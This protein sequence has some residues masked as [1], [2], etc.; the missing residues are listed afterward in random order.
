MK[1]IS[2][3]ILSLLSIILSAQDTNYVCHFENVSLARLEKL[4]TK[5]IEFSPIYYQSGLVFVEARERNSILDPKTGQA[6][7]DLMYADL[8][9]D[10]MPDKSIFFSPNIQT[11]YHEGPCTFSQ[12]GNEIF[13]TRS[14]M[15]GGQVVNDEKK[16]VQLKIYHGVKGA[17]DWEQITELPFCS[18]YYSV[19]HP[20]LSADG[21]ILVFSS[22]MPGSLGGMD[23]YM[24]KRMKDGWSE[25]VN[26]GP[27][28]NSKGNEVFPFF[29]QDGYLF[30][31]SDG[32]GGKGGLD[33]FVTSF[34]EGTIFKGLQHLSEPFN[35]N[36]DDLGL[37]V[38][39]DGMSGY[40]GSD[41]KPTT[42]KDDLYRWTSPT[43]IFCFT[44]MKPLAVKDILV[45]NESGE[46]VDMAYV[47]LIPMNQDGPSLYK[48]HFNTEL[49]PNG[50]KEGTY[51]LRLSI[52]DT[53][54]VA[55]ANSISTRDGRSQM[56]AD[57][58]L[59]YAIV[60]QR[61]GYVP[62]LQVVMGKDIPAV[63]KLTHEPEVS[64]KC[65]NTIF[66][67]FNS[68]GSNP[69][70][71]ANIMLSGQCIKVNLNIYTDPNGYIEAC[72]PTGC[73]VKAEIQKPG[74]AMHTFTFTPSEEDEK[75]TIYLK[76]AAGLTLP[77]APIASGT[78]IVLNDIF[79]DFNKSAIRKGDAEELNS[80]ANVLKKYPD[81]TIELTSHTDTRGTAEYNMKLSQQ[82]S[83]SSKSYLVSRGINGA[84]I[85][86]LAA[87]ES[88][89][90][91]HCLDGVPCTEEEHQYNRRTEVRI[92]NPAQ[93]MEVKYKSK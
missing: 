18:D 62:Y 10:G 55:S 32:R 45:T 77:A 89:P 47:W 85:T 73:P 17:E 19:C 68:S 29:H 33:L 26:L 16:R 61:E 15:S 51:Y 81:L 38:S 80:L 75:W 8:G 58:K 88:S 70:S 14:N 43:S 22:N 64:R 79:Y 6:Y 12:D 5:S 34:A 4:N 23:L 65:V 41:R 69:L 7:F 82:R 63:I 37:I 31:S 42:G 59:N 86:T 11:Q 90:R 30:F 49:V 52:Q 50:D 2:A 71:G 74:Y 66:T 21:H 36:K 67:V 35:S 40:F 72:I 13:F 54:P 3:C 53:L 76:D 78:V 39:A 60:V 25:P 9:P 24:T 57:D 91:N 46:V 87:G 28:I 44:K 56:N 20:T 1:I 48:E 84:R 93:G 27:N 83:E 92:T